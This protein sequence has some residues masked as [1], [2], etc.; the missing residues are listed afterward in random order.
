MYYVPYMLPC[1]GL[2]TTYLISKYILI[3]STTTPTEANTVPLNLELVSLVF[4]VRFP[5]AYI[6]ELNPKN[7]IMKFI[8]EI[9]KIKQLLNNNSFN[10][11]LINMYTYKFCCLNNIRTDV[12]F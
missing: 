11:L 10:T 4:S 6:R 12:F 7:L 9:K 3:S 1:L 8:Y 5:R 2:Q